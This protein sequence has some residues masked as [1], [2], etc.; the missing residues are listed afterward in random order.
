MRRTARLIAK[1]QAAGFCHGV[2]NTD[3]V[4]PARADLDY[5]PYGLSTPM[6][7]TSSAT[8]RIRTVAMRWISSLRSDTGTCRSW[9]RRWPAMWMATRSRRP[10]ANYEHQLMLHY[11]ELMRAKLGLAVWETTIRRCSA[12]CSGCWRRTGGLPPLP[13]RLGEVTRRAWP[14]ACWPCCPIL[15]SGRGL[16]PIGRASPGR[17]A[18]MACARADG[19]GQPKYVLRN[20]L[21]QQVIGGGRTGDMAPFERLFAAYSTYDDQPNTRISATPHRAGIAGA[22][23]RAAVEEPQMNWRITQTDR[24]PGW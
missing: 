20:A 14:A 7:R 19:R 11:S 13:R 8:T 17:G 22:S 23:S 18:W 10:L 5:G 24:Q 4:S 1:W 2:M 15:P 16:R 21:A 12:S 6:C 9:P 3:N